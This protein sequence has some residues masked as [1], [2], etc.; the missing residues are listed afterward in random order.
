LVKEMQKLLVGLEGK[1]ADREKIPQKDALDMVYRQFF[2]RHMELGPDKLSSLAFVVKRLHGL[3]E[4]DAM[5]KAYLF[6]LSLDDKFFDELEE[7]TS[8]MDKTSVNWWKEFCK[9]LSLTEEQKRQ[10][11]LRRLTGHRAKAE[12]FYVAQRAQSMSKSIIERK[13]LAQSFVD[14][15]RTFTNAQLAKFVI[16]VS[17]D[18]CGNELL[19][20]LWSE[21]I[22]QIDDE[23]DKERAMQEFPDDR[24]LEVERLLNAVRQ[25]N[26]RLFRSLLES[27]DKRD[28]FRNARRI[29][30][31]DIIL[32]DPSNG[33]EYRGLDQAIRYVD[34]MR[35]AFTPTAVSPS[36]EMS[37]ESSPRSD[38]LEVRFEEKSLDFA[39]DK[40]VG[41]FRIQGMYNGRLLDE[42][43]RSRH[44]PVMV[45]Y[46]CV[47]SITFADGSAKIKELVVSN[48]LVGLFQSLGQKGMETEEEEQDSEEENGVVKES[49]GAEEVPVVPS[50]TSEDVDNS[51][52]IDTV[53]DFEAML[54]E[55]EESHRMLGDMSASSNELASIVELQIRQEIISQLRLLFES[56]DREE[57]H[58]VASR[59][60]A[61][62][63]VFIDSNMGT[64]HR[65]VEECFS[66]VKRIRS[67]FPK[68]KVVSESFEK[69]SKQ[70][71]EKI[72]FD[73][74][75]E[76]NYGGKLAGQGLKPCTLK[77]VLFLTLDNEEIPSV[78]SLAMSWNAI[79]LLK[80]LGVQLKD[81]RLEGKRKNSGSV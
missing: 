14:L 3:I 23:L 17:T 51:N 74:S 65:G 18:A 37:P 10:I 26:G 22:E 34:K 71:G 1:L 47:V 45:D 15:M 21:L 78:T 66:Y 75:L 5:T 16:W 35:R 72:R 80:E 38:K 52:N 8:E 42:A 49:I 33:G 19:D 11:K 70:P 68:L 48:D 12:L 32:I 77:A 81:H 44:E 67:A 56:D 36:P 57:A 25:E 27:P 50:N 39:G 13:Y 73:W 61:E 76:A 54:F 30:A 60:L 6:I 7:P 59:I 79:S 55:E 20:M 2:E 29:F 24:A 69:D 4:P 43:S 41:K 58:Q 62:R 64:D 31:D 53:E 9:E 46:E 40:A 63:C 28:S